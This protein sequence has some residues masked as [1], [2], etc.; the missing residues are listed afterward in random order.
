MKMGL[1]NARVKWLRVFL[2]FL[3]FSFLFMGAGV[4]RVGSGPRYFLTSR[5]ANRTTPH[6]LQDLGTKTGY[7]VR[8]KRFCGA[9]RFHRV[10]SSLVGSAQPNIYILYHCFK[11]SKQLKTMYS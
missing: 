7:N 5:P 1:G 10:G 4:G 3:F 2:F 11:T 6:G 8:V 9:G